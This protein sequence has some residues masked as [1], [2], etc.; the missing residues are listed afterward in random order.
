MPFFSHYGDIEDI[1]DKLAIP[2]LVFTIVTPLFIIARFWSRKVF[3]KRF[4]ADDWVILA[5]AVTTAFE[6]S[7][8]SFPRLLS[9]LS[10]EITKPCTESCLTNSLS[11]SLSQLYFYAQIFYKIN[12]GLTK[13]SILLLYIKVFIQPW[14]RKTCWACVSVIIAFTVGTV[15][16]SIFQCTPVQYAFNKKI[17][18]GGHCLNLT[19]F[20]YANA[21]FNILSDVVIIALPI[22]VVSKLHSP[23]K[24]KI[25]VASV[26]TIGIFVCITSVLRFTTLNVATSHL[27]TPWTNI[28][29]SMWTVIEINLG[30]IC[31]CMPT[32]WR[33]LSRIFPWVSS[34]LT[35][36]KYGSG[37]S[38]GSQKPI[39]GGRRAAPTGGREVAGYW[40]KIGSSDE[41]LAR[42]YG[43][44][45][46]AE[47][48][49]RATWD[50]NM[51]TEEEEFSNTIR[52]TTQV[53]VRY[54]EGQNDPER[55]ERDIELKRVGR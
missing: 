24:T 9:R 22:P 12:I 8:F 32:L 39:P 27:D 50:E 40:T 31:A 1:S 37:Q 11:L 30:I 23:I 34:H 44:Y 45:T 51:P 42:D 43:M 28:G 52:K 6:V 47:G 25:A 48:E 16:S 13:I 41:Q 29:S 36:T 10:L 46:S 18:G 14:F 4:G 17:P 53:S 7:F 3:A 20:W 21:V 19:A 2:A 15:F 54:C 5:S 49:R 35:N 33:P 55:G 38:L 26:F